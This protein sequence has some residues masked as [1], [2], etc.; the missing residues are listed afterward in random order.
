MAINRVQEPA[1]PPTA[2]GD[3]T[4][5]IAEMRAV[6]LGIEMPLRVIGSNIV[7]GAVFQIGGTLYLADADTAISGSA[8]NYVK[9]T[10]S[11]DGSVC[12]ASFVSSLTGV[13]WNST[14]CGWYDTG[15]PAS[16]YEFDEG[17]AFTAGQI[18]AIRRNRDVTIPMGTGWLAVLA[19]ALGANWSNALAA[20]AGAGILAQLLTVD[21]VGSGLDAD[22][23]E[24]QHAGNSSGQIPISNGTRCVGLNADK[25]AGMLVSGE[26]ALDASC[27]AVGSTLSGGQSIQ[28]SIKPNGTLRGTKTYS[29]IVAAIYPSI[30]ATYRNI[31]LIHGVIRLSGAYDIVVDSVVWNGENALRFYGF[32]SSGG[33]VTTDIGLGGT[34][35]VVS[36]AW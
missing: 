2:I 13:V 9:I 7:K 16:F 24:G 28:S 1:N 23:L 25:V 33:A 5:I 3:W 19:A 11:G 31:I 6:A 27:L 12:T 29:E 20:S 26:A 18:A 4:K 15:S 34:T 30:N 32:N 10:P 17:K 14:Y 22:L 8:S 35:A 36:L 21:G